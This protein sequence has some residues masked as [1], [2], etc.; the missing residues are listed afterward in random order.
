MEEGI[1]LEELDRMKSEVQRVLDGVKR[2]D[3]HLGM[4]EFR[5]ITQQGV[6]LISIMLKSIPIECL[7]KGIND[8]FDKFL[9]VE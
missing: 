2:D 7:E 8:W 5:W 9:K 1:T 4:T 6:P 3:C